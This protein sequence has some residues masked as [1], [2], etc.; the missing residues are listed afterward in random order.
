[1]EI[2]RFTL[3]DQ[4]YSAGPVDLEDNTLYNIYMDIEYFCT[5]GLNHKDVWESVEDIDQ[6]FVRRIGCIIEDRTEYG[7]YSGNL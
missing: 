6:R 3:D 5:I 4:I 2:I 1:M 7:K